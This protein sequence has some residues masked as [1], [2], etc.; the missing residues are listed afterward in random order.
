[1]L[2]HIILPFT[3]YSHISLY[4]YVLR[5]LGNAKAEW[6]ND[7]IAGCKHFHCLIFPFFCYTLACVLLVTLAAVLVAIL[8]VCL[9][10]E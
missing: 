1:M 6:A 8:E 2:L 4:S 9:D 10:R 7:A 5:Q 3:L